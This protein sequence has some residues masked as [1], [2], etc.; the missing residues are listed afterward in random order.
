[1]SGGEQVLALVAEHGP[2]VVLVFF[3][4]LAGRSQRRGHTRGSGQER[5]RSDR[6]RNRY[7]R[8]HAKI[9]NMLRAISERL[10]PILLGSELVR[11]LERNEAAADRLDAVIRELLA[12]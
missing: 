9:L 12:S 3:S 5:D 6:D 1:M 10:H 4:A 2:W 11:A 7:S 8:T